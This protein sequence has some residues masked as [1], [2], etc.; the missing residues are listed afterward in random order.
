M[1]DDSTDADQNTHVEQRN[2]EG[3]PDELGEPGEDPPD[4][5]ADAVPDDEEGEVEEEHEE[6]MEE[7]EE[8]ELEPGQH[9]NT[10][11]MNTTAENQTN[12]DNG[13]DEMPN[14]GPN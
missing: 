6:A 11:K 3:I 12:D 14:Q 2:E 13:P 8:E 7:R 1:T 9:K 5:T 4:E 10:D